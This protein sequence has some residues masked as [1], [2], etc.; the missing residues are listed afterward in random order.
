MQFRGLP[1]TMLPGD[2]HCA[3]AHVVMAESLAGVL[4]SLHRNDSWN[5]TVNAAILSRLA[6]VRQL[7]D[8]MSLEAGKQT[9]EDD[10]EEE[11]EEEDVKEVDEEN[12]TSAEEK[13]D[14]PGTVI[15]TD[16]HN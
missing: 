2:P 6:L 12:A 3:P 10:H 1:E 15:H 14:S 9:K 16:A 13:K 5:G 7:V 4:R 11:E 8:Q